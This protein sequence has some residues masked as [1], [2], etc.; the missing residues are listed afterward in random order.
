M[1]FSQ[2]NRLFERYAARHLNVTL[3]GLTLTDAQ[4]AVIGY[5]E[6]V[7]LQGGRFRVMGWVQAKSVTLILGNLR[8]STPPHLNRQDVAEAVG[9][10]AQVGFD[11]SVP[12]IKGESTLVLE[13]DQGTVD[14]S[15]PVPG[16]AA[17]QRERLR[18]RGVFTKKML[19]LAPAIVR[20]L[21]TRDMHLRRHIRDALDL[22]PVTTA[23]LLDTQLFGAEEGTSDDEAV[24]Q[25]VTG[26]T[27]ILPVYN[28]FELL[29]DVLECVVRHTDV[30]WRLI[31]MEDRSSDARVRP[32]LR[33]WVT[34]ADAGGHDVVL[35]E[36][37]ENLGFI[38][39][40]NAGLTKALAFKDPVVLLNSDAFVP[41]AW[42]SRL[43]E[44]I[45][46][47]P[48]VATVT[49][50][51]N[52]AEIFS[53]PQI[54]V[55]VPLQAGQGAAMDL[56]TRQFSPVSEP[57]ETPTGVGFCMAMNIDFLQQVPALDTVFGRGYGEEVDWCRK[58]A[59]LGGRH[60]AQ[61]GLFVEHRGGESFGSEEKLRLVQKNNAVIGRRYPEYDQ[62]VQE[63]IQTDPLLTPRLAL[64]VA[65]VASLP[66]VAEVPVFVAHSMG[67]GADMYLEDR[68]AALTP[69][70]A[71]VVRMG[72][73]HR[74]QIE[75]VTPHGIISGATGDLA[76]ACRMVHLAPQ[77]RIIYSCAVGDVDPVALPA[78][79][80]DMAAGQPIDVL[81][82]DYFPLSPSY[83]LLGSDG[84]YH[85]AAVPPHNDSAHSHKRADGHITSL[86]AWQQAWGGLLAQAQRLVVFSQ[87][88]Q[89]LVAATYADAA[90][91]LVLEPHELLTGM[92]PVVP[93]ASTRRVI[94][95]LGNI[96]QQKGA[97]VLSRLSRRIAVLEDADLVIIGNVDPSFSLG[98][99]TRVHGSYERGDIADLIAHYGITMWLIPS[100][101]PETFSYTTHEAL[102]T[103][104]PVLSFDF[105]AQGDA[106][107]AA[108]N[109][110]V[111]A[112]PVG[113]RQADQLAESVVKA[114]VSVSEDRGD[115][116]VKTRGQ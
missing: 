54:C 63:F 65:Y 5:V 93:A 10:S 67:G 94:G 6:Q 43:L 16:R 44:P 40:V 69:Q 32:F 56:A 75:V 114:V 66:D 85:G 83:T 45:W 100:V 20:G 4:G 19:L 11:V 107:A 18:L 84:T 41:K 26:V 112:A 39:S 109:G 78:F 17:I 47:D 31:I 70:A 102:S 96:G 89:R 22:N 101:W 68:I 12:A 53:V 86:D 62:S 14:F 113:A 24:P 59:A 2:F 71:I 108:S 30:N 91:K 77:R 50:M 74:V 1:I 33:E 88:S 52:D 105:G 46:R 92:S 72:G 81:F 37:A 35:V 49:P 29:E 79:M 76:F 48:L 25:Q 34:G 98:K 115:T 87:D 58:T 15:V 21:A 36:N 38:G 64:A 23:V 9:C 104:L 82:H 27:I 99:G 7:C 111:I 8:V 60:V 28:A 80:L 103:G 95:V 42:A 106:V 110:Y 90:E 73:A 3:G 51:S 61:T 57:I 97:A 55:R 13:T 116:Y